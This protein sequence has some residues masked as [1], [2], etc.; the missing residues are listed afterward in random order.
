MKHQVSKDI[1]VTALITDEQGNV[2]I[3]KPSHKDGWIFPGGYVEVGESPSE[4]CRREILAELGVEVN[5]PNKLLSVDYHS[6]TSEYVMFMF[7]GGVF[8]DDMI[9]SITLPPQLLEFRFVPPD[10]ALTLLRA[11]SARRLMPSLESRH[12]TGIAYLEHEELF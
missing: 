10:E 2:L 12:Q 8:T 3:V 5:G 9:A 4:A 7:D 6:R 1:V 11:N